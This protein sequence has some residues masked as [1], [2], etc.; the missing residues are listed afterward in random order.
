MCRS[1]FKAGFYI[2]KVNMQRR[3]YYYYYNDRHL[4]VTFVREFEQKLPK[5]S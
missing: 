1:A 4:F 3:L 5:D 2:F